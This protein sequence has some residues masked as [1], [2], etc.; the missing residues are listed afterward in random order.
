MILSFRVST[1]ILL[2]SSAVAAFMFSHANLIYESE[3]GILPTVF[4]GL[5]IVPYIFLALKKWLNGCLASFA[6]FFLIIGN[7]LFYLIKRIGSG[8]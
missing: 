3:N 8:Y 2:P 4:Y 7:Y 1:Y 6:L 5:I